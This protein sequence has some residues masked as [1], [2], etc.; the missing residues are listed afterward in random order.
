MFFYDKQF[1]HTIWRLSDVGDISKGEKG[2]PPKRL[3]PHEMTMIDGFSGLGTV[4]VAAKASGFKV[5]IIISFALPCLCR[6]SS[7]FP[8]F[9]CIEGLWQASWTS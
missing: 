2:A 6:R 4:S 8:K 7:H 9:A 5:P 1:D 3:L